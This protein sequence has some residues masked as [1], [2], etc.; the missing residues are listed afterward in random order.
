M[1]ASISEALVWSMSLKNAKTA[2]FTISSKK[3]CIKSTGWA[4]NMPYL[5]PPKESRLVANS[6]NVETNSEDWSW[7]VWQ[8]QHH[9][10]ETCG[11]FLRF[12]VSVK[13]HILLMCLNT[14]LEDNCMPC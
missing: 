13:K 10:T 6:W 4:E 12:S 11:M 3:Q 1:V 2:Y 8:L 9:L 5:S 7:P 14:Q